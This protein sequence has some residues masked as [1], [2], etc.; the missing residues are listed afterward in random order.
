MFSDFSKKLV[1]SLSIWW[2]LKVKDFKTEGYHKSKLQ[3]QGQFPPVVFSC[4]QCNYLL[5]KE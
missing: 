5:H 4:S 2:N 1:S 3:K